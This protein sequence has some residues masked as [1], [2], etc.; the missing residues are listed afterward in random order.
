MQRMQCLALYLCLL[1]TAADIEAWLG[2][3]LREGTASSF[4]TNGD[5]V[6]ES[7]RA[8]GQTLLFV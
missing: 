3:V 7:P 1:A 2:V 6:W 4:F 5:C 8:D